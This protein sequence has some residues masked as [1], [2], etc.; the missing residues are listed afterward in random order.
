M[1]R[2][3]RQ[4]EKVGGKDLKW[5]QLEGDYGIITANILKHL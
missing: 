3:F 4:E 2:T 1:T 5:L